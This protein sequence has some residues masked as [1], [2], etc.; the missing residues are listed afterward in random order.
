MIFSLFDE[1]AKEV[2][3]VVTYVFGVYVMNVLDDVLVNVV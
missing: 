2:V 1:K 3:S